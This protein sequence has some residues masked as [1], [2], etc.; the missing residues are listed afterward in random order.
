M[1]SRTTITVSKAAARLFHA[2]RERNGMEKSAFLELAVR[3]L[4]TLTP[5]QRMAVQLRSDDP[6][7]SPSLGDSD[8]SL[9]VATAKQA[10]RIHPSRPARRR[11]G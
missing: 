6:I 8:Q 7:A 11:A 2:V 10:P 3:A 9:N 5:E 1:S 4:E